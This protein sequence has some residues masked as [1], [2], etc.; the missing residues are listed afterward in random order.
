MHL[1]NLMKG[2]KK[3]AYKIPIRQN[4]QKCKRDAVYEV[5]NYVNS[6]M[7]CFCWPCANREVKRLKE[8]EDAPS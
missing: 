8:A 6:S 3:M 5:F 1:E 2:Y 4:C 7:G